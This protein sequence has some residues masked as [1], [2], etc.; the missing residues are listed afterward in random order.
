VTGSVTVSFLSDRERD[1][2][3]DCDEDGEE[4]CDLCREGSSERDCN[5]EGDT[6]R[7]TVTV[8]GGA[9]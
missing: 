7:V 1:G 8:T 9:H 5:R 6:E 3:R 4:D 2:D